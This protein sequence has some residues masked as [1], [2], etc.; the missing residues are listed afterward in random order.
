MIALL[1]CTNLQ[2]LF[3]CRAVLLGI[4]QKRSIWIE[5]EAADM[6]L[7]TWMLGPHY[8]IAADASRAATGAIEPSPISENAPSIL[9]AGK[10]SDYKCQI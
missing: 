10:L 7:G 9:P 6:L 5:E 4:E 2:S 1:L 3:Y 8:R